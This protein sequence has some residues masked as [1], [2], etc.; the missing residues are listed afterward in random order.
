M[1]RFTRQVNELAPA[2]LGPRIDRTVSVFPDQ[3]ARIDTMIREYNGDLYLFAVRVSEVE[4]DDYG[5]GYVD[6]QQTYTVKATLMINDVVG[7]DVEVYEEGRTLDLDYV[8][9]DDFAP[10][11]VHIY[12]L[13]N[14]VNSNEVFYPDF[15]GTPGN[16]TIDLDWTVHGNLPTN[17]TW[18]IDYQ[19]PGGPPPSPIVDLA[20]P[21]RNLTLSNL[22]NGEVY[23]IT[24]S[25]IQNGAV[26]QTNTIQITPRE[27]VFLPVVLK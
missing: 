22:T 20:N 5:R 9:V 4:D 15:Q 3:T 13:T 26:I 1:T 8:L 19:G 16:E 27:P 7:A 11:D 21:T 25:A 23:T 18:R 12:K 14:I 24:L 17:V 10:Y 6:P 2:I